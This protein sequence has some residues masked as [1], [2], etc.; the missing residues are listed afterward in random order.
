ML[1]PGSLALQYSHEQKQ[2][3]QQSAEPNVR[4]Y[5]THQVSPSVPRTLQH[6]GDPLYIYIY[7][8]PPLKC[9]WELVPGS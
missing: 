5:V 3:L 8:Y 1:R 9:V 7:I 4:T 6:E 2:H